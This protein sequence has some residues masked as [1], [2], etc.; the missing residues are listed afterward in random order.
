[1]GQV[2]HI[3]EKIHGLNL[4]ALIRTLHQL[5]FK[6]CTFKLLVHSLTPLIIGMGRKNI[7]QQGVTGHGVRFNT[8]HFASTP[9]SSAF[10]T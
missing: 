10:F 8:R 1:M 9:S 6:G 4:Y 3:M 5:L 7:P 2:F